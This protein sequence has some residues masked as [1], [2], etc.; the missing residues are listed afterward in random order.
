MFAWKA[1][2]IVGAVETHLPALAEAMQE[3]VRS[4]HTPE[5]SGAIA[6]AYDKVEAISIDYGVM[7]KADNVLCIPVDVGW[8]DVGSGVSLEDVWGRDGRGNSFKGEVVNLD[9][10]NCI[11][12]SPHKLTALIGV[13][14]LIVVDTADVLMICRKDRAQDVKTLQEALKKKGYDHLL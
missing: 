9:T 5:K 6:H 10:R 4:L 2:R 8:N 11:V 7:E 12:S 1:S 3:T 13:E 14:D